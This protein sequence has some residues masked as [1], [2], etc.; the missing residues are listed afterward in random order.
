MVWLIVLGLG[1]GLAGVG[2]QKKSAQ[3]QVV[4]GFVV[5][6]PEEPWFQ[7]EWKFAQ[8]AADKYGFKLVKIGAEDGEKT[9][10]VIDNLIAQG[11]K[12]LVICPSDT[13][14]G[15]AIVAKTSAAGMKLMSV[16]DQLVGANGKAMDVHHL[17]ISASNIGKMV[18]QTLSEQMK[19]RGWKAED[20]G[21]CIVTWEVIETGRQRTDGAA[22]ALVAAG[23]PK[24]R[25]FKAPEKTA[26]VPGSMDAVNVLLTQH[27]EVKHWL[28]CSTNDN[29][30]MGGIRAMEGR[31]FDA[32]NVIGVG[33]NGTDCLVEFRKD[34]PTGF[35]GSILLAPRRHGYETAEMMYLW[36]TQGKEPPKA[37]FTD[38]IL[39]TRDTYQQIM[40]EQGLLE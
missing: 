4:I 28:V 5:K 17:G 15:P 40:K 20:T 1:L 11:A 35:W 10:Q 9:L 39:I 19:Q 32:S 37:T 16:D 24:E 36:I 27:P 31:G 33:I 29:G 14:L 2:C 34:K 22:A 38:G 13:H 30:V 21:L 8:Q 25:I 7:N 26:D 6:Q 3:D 12:G 23:F 18:G